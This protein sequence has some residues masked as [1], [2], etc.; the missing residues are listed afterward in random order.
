MANPNLDRS[1]R[2]EREV[3]HAAEDHDVQAERAWA[4]NGESL[5]EHE[6]C[7]VRLTAPDGTKVTVQ[8]K[9]RKSIAQYLTCENASIV[10]VRED[11]GQNLAVVPLDDYLELLREG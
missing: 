9:R 3:V 10:V 6:E 1:K 11:H 7:D 8:A 5:G 2:H 4:S